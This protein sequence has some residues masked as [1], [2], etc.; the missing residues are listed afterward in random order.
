[1]PTLPPPAS[2]RPMTERDPAQT[3]DRVRVEHDVR[4]LVREEI[5][6]LSAY[7]VQPAAGL[8][9][10][11][12]MENPYPWPAELRQDWLTRLREAPL[13]RYPDPTAAALQARLRADWGLPPGVELLLG[14]GSDEL[15]QLLVMALARPGAR[16]LIPEPTFVMY[17]QLAQSVGLACEAVPL[18]ADFD[19]DLPAMLA[20]MERHRPAIVFLAQPNNPTGQL[21]AP[22]VL[23]RLVEAAPGLVVVDEAYAPFADF[24]ALPWLAGRD[25]LIVLRTFSKLGLAGLR[26]GVLAAPA[27]WQAALEKIRLPYN[28]GVLTQLTMMHVLDHP[29]VLA[30]QAAAICAERARLQAALAALPGVEVWPSQANFLLFRVRAGAPRVHHRLR[31]AGVLIKCLHGAHPLLADCLRVTVGTPAENESFLHG[32]RAAL[33]AAPG[34]L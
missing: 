17:R 9:K 15:I 5:Q 30:D 18:R 19:L 24:T 1:M 23:A 33:A 13:H 3:P 6:A 28:V 25:N 7:H 29:D 12:A 10:L 22:E 21:L 27:G 2:R 8:I 14:N 34:P 32:L 11:D 31:E 16:V 26:L 4:R 20:A